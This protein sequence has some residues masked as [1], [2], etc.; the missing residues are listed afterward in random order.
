MNLPLPY[1]FDLEFMQRA[2]VAGLAIGIA[3]PLIGAFLVQRRMAL[4]GDGIGH[5]AFAG[6]AAGLLAGVWPIWTALLASIA[7]AVLI[8]WLRAL[9]KA[10]GDLALAL[11]FYGGIALGNVLAYKAGASASASTNS[12]LFGSVLTVDMGDVRVVV[13]L[14]ALVM[15]VIA[16]AGRAL[17]SVV[18]DPESA[19]VAGLPVRALELLLAVLAAITI[20]G[21]IRVVG[22]LLVASLMVLPVATS[23]L[24]A[25]SFASTL[26]IAS[27]IGALSVIVG[28]WC[29]RAFD[30]APGGAIVLTA[31]GWF[32]VGVVAG[33]V[34]GRRVDV[35]TPH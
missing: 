2:L 34:R 7:A 8:E 31:C 23:R 27:A 9:D 19:R 1:P 29:S 28:L 21:A 10:T 20:A 14:A 4:L 35:L 24:I 30:V 3:A 18:V 17:F 32:V 11:F 5:V 13:G 16:V 12:Y 26:G 22:T 25:R 33:V 6:V 15:V